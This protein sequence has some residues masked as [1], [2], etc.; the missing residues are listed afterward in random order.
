MRQPT[1]QGTGIWIAQPLRSVSGLSAAHPFL[2]D[3][4]IAVAI[5]AVSV[6]GLS[7]QHRLHATTL[8]FCGA[9]CAP[10]LLRR[11]SH[12]LC[13]TTVATV[14]LAQW[15]LA[16]P[17]SADLAV[18]VALYWVVL[19]GSLAEGAIA[20][21]VVE[22]GAI[23]AALRWSYA[24]TFKVWVGLSGLATAAGVLGITIR[25]RRAL[26]ASLQ[27]RAARLEVERDQEG[28]L[29]AAA[30]RARIAR[31][32]HD[33]VAHNLSVMI[34]LADG[35]TYAMDDSP[36]SAAQATRRVS[37][38]GREALEEMRRLLGVLH[39]GSSQQPLEP[40]PSLDRLDELLERVKA[41]GIPVTMQLDG[42][43]RALT[44]GVQLAVFRVAQEALTNTLKHAARPAR[45]HLL[46][47]CRSGQ[48]EL[49]VTDTGNAVAG[50]PV[51]SG[52]STDGRG[53]RGMQERAAA[54]GGMVD[55]GP[56][57]EGGWRV[58]LRLHPDARLAT[59]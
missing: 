1:A 6:V 24:A 43:P 48:V 42:D 56:S 30:E 21:A 2:S 16:G 55:A 51:R 54:Y 28:R 45:A 47:S 12:R 38:T 20:G 15:L 31:E 14:A 3:L 41:A 57:P 18:L 23:M 19:E 36:A 35:A 37:A 59:L 58:L 40:Q 8:I 10:L 25:Q 46:L 9:L 50:A 34:A 17:Q 26:L 52:G 5:A 53:L 32:M 29:A 27:E 33:I 22:L 44:D 11:L 49:E 13:F 4:S 39:D 7:T